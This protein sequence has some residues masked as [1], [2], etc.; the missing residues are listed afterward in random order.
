MG[1][2]YFIS[3]GLCG[4]GW[5]IDLARIPSLVKEANLKEPIQNRVSF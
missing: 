3:G 2:L 1:A 5:L 4:I